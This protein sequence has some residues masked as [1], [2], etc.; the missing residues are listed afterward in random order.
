[1]AGIQTTVSLN[2]RM[3]SVL[4]SINNSLRG[5][6]TS[7]GQ[8]NNSI[9]NAFDGGLIGYTNSLM[10]NTI[11]IVD[12]I[13]NEINQ[14]TS[15]QNRF[16][17]VL[18]NSNKGLDSIWSTLKG[19]VGTYASIQGAKTLINL[20]DTSVQNTARLNNMNST[21]GDGQYSTAELEDL[22]FNTAQKTGIGYNDM[23]DLV[24]KFGNNASDAF[25]SSAEVVA[26][27]DLVNKQL[28][29]D[30]ASVEGANSAKFQLT[31]ALGAGVLQGEE[32]N[33]ILDATPNLVQK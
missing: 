31:Q 24:S 16:N 30:G 22:I 17:S 27:T 20:S 23:V 6:T 33:S 11:D 1:M 13:G 2:D 9:S 26:F 14:N 7:L 19:I 12:N 29:I 21:I 18:Q 4:N 5:T 25:G 8:V 32:L 3:T 10:N 15:L 28:F